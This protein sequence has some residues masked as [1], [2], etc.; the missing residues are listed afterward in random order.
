M[1]QGGKFCIGV[2]SQGDGE[3]GELKFRMNLEYPN[4]EVIDF[5]RRNFNAAELEQ[6]FATRVPLRLVPKHGLLKI[7]TNTLGLP[8]N[9][10]VV[11]VSSTADSSLKLLLLF[12]GEYVDSQM[13][14]RIQALESLLGKQ[15]LDPDS[16]PLGTAK[17]SKSR[18]ELLGILAKMDVKRLFD[19]E[20]DLLAEI[21]NGLDESK[22]KLSVDQKP[23][24][25]AVSQFVLK[26]RLS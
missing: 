22:Y 24:F 13:A 12:G 4:K 5:I 8:Q 2:V 1:I 17:G 16:R 14:A 20:F 23:K 18:D 25:R 11:P 21:V 26:K 9:S 15:G 19:Y 6:I 3:E 10:L 7:V